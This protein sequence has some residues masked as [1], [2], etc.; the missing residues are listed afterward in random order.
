M[1]E[2]IDRERVRQLGADEQAQ[3]VEV[4]GRDDYEQAHL[5]GARHI[6]VP[7]LDERAPHELDPDRPVVV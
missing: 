6:W 7:T 3:L 1:P 2:K 4:L 5:P